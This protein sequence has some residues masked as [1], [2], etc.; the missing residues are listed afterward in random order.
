MS[1]ADYIVGSRQKRRHSRLADASVGIA[2]AADKFIGTLQHSKVLQRN[3]RFIPE[4]GDF[5]L[6]RS[7][8]R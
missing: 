2:P 7:A 3:S 8:S 5:G 4:S 1:A 6:A